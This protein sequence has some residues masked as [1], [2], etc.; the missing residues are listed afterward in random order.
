MLKYNFQINDF[1][2]LGGGGGRGARPLVPSASANDTRQFKR[3]NHARCYVPQRHVTFF[4]GLVFR[5]PNCPP[6]LENLLTRPPGAYTTCTQV[7]LP[8]E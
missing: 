7:P 4:L 6:T 5:P 8:R 3:F 1:F 2:F